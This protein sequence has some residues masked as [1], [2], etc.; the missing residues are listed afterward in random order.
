[1][2]TIDSRECG[3]SVT[4]AIFKTDVLLQEVEQRPTISRSRH[5]E[6]NGRK[7]RQDLAQERK[8]GDFKTVSVKARNPL[9]EESLR[10]MAMAS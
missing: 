7:V 6:E 10:T 2:R 1:L 3:N 8:R 5:P 4:P 9:S